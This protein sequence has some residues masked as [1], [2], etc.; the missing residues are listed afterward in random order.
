MLLF[1]LLLA[2]SCGKVIDRRYDRSQL[3]AGIGGNALQLEPGWLRGRGYVCRQEVCVEG[4]TKGQCN[5]ASAFN[6]N[7]STESSYVPN[8]FCLSF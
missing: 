8:C 5:R 6:A 2:T 3:G 4:R 1:T 7:L